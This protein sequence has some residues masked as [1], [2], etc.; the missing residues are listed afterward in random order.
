M[1]LKLKLK[2]PFI[3]NLGCGLGNQPMADAFLANT[4]QKYIGATD[5]IDG[6][7]SDFFAIRFFYEL[8]QNNRTE[9]EAFKLA[10][11]TDSETKLFE[12]FE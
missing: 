6:A 1:R 5:D 10:R 12:W 4:C 7:S 2:T 9:K 3:V 11:S 8:C